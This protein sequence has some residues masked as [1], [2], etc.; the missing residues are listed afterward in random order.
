MSRN[1]LPEL[2][3][4]NNYE[5]FNIYADLSDKF[6]TQAKTDKPYDK[7]NFPKEPIS[8][9]WIPIV[10]GLGM[11]IA[12]LIKLQNQKRQVALVVEAVAHI[13]HRLDVP[14]EGLV[15]SFKRLNNLYNFYLILKYE[16]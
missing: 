3:H 5:A 8:I 10:I 12:Q 15:V 14:M 1:F 7:G 16:S 13:L 2:K 6:L 9:F 11:F 4:N